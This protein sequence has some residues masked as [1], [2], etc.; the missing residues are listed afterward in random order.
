MG[1]IP[2]H[3]LARQEY[4]QRLQAPV[5]FRARAGKVGPSAKV[6]P[7]CHSIPGIQCS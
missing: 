3:K 6:D 7:L 1:N 2:R 5:E 4:K